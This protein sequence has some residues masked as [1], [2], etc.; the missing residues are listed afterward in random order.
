MTASGVSRHAAAALE[1]LLIEMADDEFV[2]GFMDSEW[3]GIAP[4]LEEDVAMSS[5]AQDEL[6]HARALYELLAGLRADGLDADAIA[7]DREPDDY[8]HSALLDHARGD[9]A[10]TMA[11]RVLYETA[12]AA[13]L[14]SIG[15]GWPPLAELVGK[16]RREERYHGMH[17]AIWANRLAS[18]GGDAR[19]RFVAALEMLAPDAG[20][21]LAPVR[22]EAAL[23]DA[24][25][26]GRPFG[27][28][29]AAWRLELAGLLGPLG[30]HLEL[31][32]A[33]SPR[34]AA[35][36]RSE[37]FH[38]LWGEFTSVRRSDP[39]ATW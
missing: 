16:V 38:W 33:T 15:G 31:P 34:A 28:A 27:D 12:D 24:G 23:L 20:S 1:G 26:L 37:A 21:V 7:Y 9:W 6:G 29:A 13:R 2:I 4:I 36:P 10:T 18:A 8:R 19:R 5:I 11:R 39:G 35:A 17:A 30:I 32:L 3:T 22:D 25:I 14:A